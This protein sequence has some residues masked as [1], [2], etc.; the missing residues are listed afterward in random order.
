VTRGEAAAQRRTVNDMETPPRPAETPDPCA[1]CSKQATKRCKTCA[2]TW[3]CSKECQRKHW[4]SHKLVCFS[5]EELPGLIERECRAAME[6]MVF[7]EF[8][9]CLRAY[10]S[11][12][13]AL[14]PGEQGHGRRV[15]AL[16]RVQSRE[17]L[18]P[19]LRQ[20]GEHAFHVQFGDV[21]ASDRDE[22][23]E[24][25]WEIMLTPSRSTTRVRMELQNV[26]DADPELYKRYREN[27]T[28]DGKKQAVF[29][30]RGELVPLEDV[31]KQ[32]RALPATAT[33]TPIE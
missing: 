31:L 17:Q 13:R 18:P 8:C 1:S 25:T 11:E 12:L 5:D 29:F 32:L 28:L 33:T 4:P 26:P 20:Y 10:N 14:K 24:A 15:S 19:D 30:S 3:Y 22:H 6:S 16:V 9:A 23:G 27:G 7:A 21:S 2:V